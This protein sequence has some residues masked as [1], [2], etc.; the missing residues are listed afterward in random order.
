MLPT[1]IDQ[2]MKNIFIFGLDKEEP[3]RLV[4]L[5][6]ALH[7]ELFY[8]VVIGLFAGKSKRIALIWLSL[9]LTYVAV[10]LILGNHDF[11][12]RYQI[13]PAAS[14]PFSIGACLY[15]FRDAINQIISKVP[16]K[17]VLLTSLMLYALPFFWAK[18][19][20]NL[21]KGVWLDV[22]MIPFYLNMLFSALVIV[23]FSNI[24]RGQYG[25][26]EKIDAFLGSL[27]YPVYLFHFQAGIMAVSILGFTPRK[28]LRLLVFGGILTIVIALIEARF[29]S[30]Y[31]E[32][33]REK[34]KAGLSRVDV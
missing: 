5:A 4:P 3:V 11:A 17:T 33:L 14:L 21:S 20:I 6:W 34:N 12:L 19:L 7:L 1:S 27:S 28:S 29:L 2:Y 32:R 16:W 13:I 31:I 30:K 23:A 22:F 9:S 8:Y 26:I 24:P 15:H 25:L 10:L 18:S